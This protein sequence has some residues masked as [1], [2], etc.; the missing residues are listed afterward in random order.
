VRKTME[1]LFQFLMKFFSEKFYG[2]IT[3]KFEHGK[4]THVEVET[5]RIFAYKDLP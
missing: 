1:K 4:V 3:I 5:K 2:S